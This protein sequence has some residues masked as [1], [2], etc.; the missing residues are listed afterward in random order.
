MDR[1]PQIVKAIKDA[2]K[3]EEVRGIVT[4]LKK[5]EL[6]QIANSLGIPGTSSLSAAG[7]V[8]RIVSDQSM[9]LLFE[10]GLS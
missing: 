1:I 4:G 2:K 6:L 9:R 8:D 3:S 10:W 5:P 7:L